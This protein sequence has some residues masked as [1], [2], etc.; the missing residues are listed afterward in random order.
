M[1]EIHYFSNVNII[2]LVLVIYWPPLQSVFQTEALSFSDIV[3][4]IFIG[5][6]VLISSEVLKW[7]FRRR[8]RRGTE[9]LLTPNNS[10]NV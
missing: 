2:H 6:S 5:S 9:M 3:L 1:V 8:R 4:L 10:L 7:Y